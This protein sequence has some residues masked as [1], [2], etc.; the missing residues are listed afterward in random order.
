MVLDLPYYHLI[1]S[2]W[3]K[4]G[5]P[6]GT[7]LLAAAD[8]LQSN[9]TA[10]CSMSSYLHT[11]ANQ[12]CWKWQ[13]DNENPSEWRRFL[14]GNHVTPQT[15]KHE[16]LVSF[17]S[18][19]HRSSQ[20]VIAYTAS[21][22]ADKLVCCIII[23]RPNQI[24]ELLFKLKWWG[25]YCL[26]M[27]SKTKGQLGLVLVWCI[28]IPNQFIAFIH[29]TMKSSYWIKHHWRVWIEPL[30]RWAWCFRPSWWCLTKAKAKP[31]DPKMGNGPLKSI[32]F[33]QLFR[34]LGTVANPRNNRLSV[35]AT[36]AK[37]CMHCLG[38]EEI[39]KK[40]YKKP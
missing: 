4:D 32:F 26:H 12:M 21:P 17:S 39:Q 35:D 1:K 30:L 22:M 28:V 34:R 31:D 11:C 6:C 10:I 23:F 2:S 33:C 19:K 27:L 14:E 36:T 20:S 8:K 29:F 38:K 5:E 9:V 24:V 40:W 37:H 18:A 3:Q 15:E 13:Q 7:S 25:C 16:T